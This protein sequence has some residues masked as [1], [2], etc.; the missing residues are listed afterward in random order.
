MSS[1]YIRFRDAFAAAHP[2]ERLDVN[3]REWGVIR[4][5]GDGQELI[6][7][8]GTL[9]RADIFWQQIAAL[10]GRAGILALSYPATG[11]IA[12]WADDIAALMDRF[13]MSSATVL[14]SSLGG[15]VAQF[16]AATM[17]GRTDGLIA[18]NTLSS[19]A[20]LDRI[21]PYSHDLANT[22]I[23]ALRAGFIDGITAWAG[24]NPERKALE[25]FLVNEVQRRIGEGEMRTR[26][27]ALKT[28]PALPPQ[29]V[30]RSRIF[31]VEAEDDQLIRKPVRDAV[32]TH[33]DPA[34]TFRFAHGGHFPYILRPDV[35]T[36]MVA[37][38]LGLEETDDPWPPGPISIA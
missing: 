4:I 10:H 1:D 36:A 2:E 22:P 12:D 19:V 21:P 26:L 9:G 7:M 33:L 35:Y 32:R 18:A 31:V 37:A 8:P 23:E 25:T 38:C 14:G 15:Y 30:D 28:G 29:S 13:G 16:F 20:G 34:R 11:G 24:D 27:S 5:E 6:L 17:P 3:G